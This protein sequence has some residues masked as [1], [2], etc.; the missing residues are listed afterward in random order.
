[1]FCGKLA[2]IQT[3][4]FQSSFSRWRQSCRKVCNVHKLAA[5]CRLATG[6][7]R[8]VKFFASG[9][10]TT[11][12]PFCNGGVDFFTGAWQSATQQPST[13]PLL[14]VHASSLQPRRWL[15]VAKRVRFYSPSA[16]HCCPLV[17]L[18][19]YR[20][21]SLCDGHFVTQ[22]EMLRLLLP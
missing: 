14:S 11:S 3:P 5:K 1:M 4:D 21:P 12:T 8:F 20:F 18:W 22:V 7:Q 2:V 17:T 15:A 9:Y 6:G 16:R 13:M 19:K 10:F